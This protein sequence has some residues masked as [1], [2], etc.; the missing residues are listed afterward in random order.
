MSFSTRTIQG[1]EGRLAVTT[2]GEGGLPVLFVHGGGANRTQ[3]AAQQA[4]LAQRNVSFD[5]RGMGESD[6]D[7]KGRY[8]F[9]DFARDVGTVADALHLERFALVGHSFGCA[10][11]SEYAANH[12]ER[13]A[14]LVLGDPGPSPK[15]QPPE[16]L[17]LMREG[18]QPDRYEAARLDWFEPMLRG[19]RPETRQAVLASLCATPR[20]VIVT[21]TW[22]LLD[23]DPVELLSRYP[24]PCLAISA[25]ATLHWLGARALHLRVPGMRVEALHGVSHWLM[26]DAPDAFNAVLDEFLTDVQAHLELEDAM[27]PGPT[28]ASGALTL[29]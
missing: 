1:P 17:E 20:E 21:S 4:Y 10:V 27:P 12:P 6:P 5:L 22:S 2:A 14:G 24:G 9:R 7:P 15:E 16:M 19:A 8:S 18:F 25:E 29:S 23:Y 13:V 26:M 3:W 28:D 11:V